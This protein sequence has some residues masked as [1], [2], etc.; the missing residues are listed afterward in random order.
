MNKKNL[1]EQT[2]EK[3][4]T[5]IAVEK[6]IKAGHKLPNE[7][8]LS[9]Q[10]GVSRTTLREAIRTLTARGVLE[11]RRG[12]G[13]FVSEK[14]GEI[15]DFGFSNLDQMR[16]RL[17]DLFELR[18][19]FEP[20]AAGLACRRATDEELAE[21]LR[22]GE[23]VEQYIRT[24]KDRTAADRE[25]HTAIVRAAHNEFMMRLLPMINQAVGEAI[26][27]GENAEA[28]AEHTLRDHALLMD[29]LRKRDEAGAEHAMA[30]HMHH[31]IDA[32]NLE[33]K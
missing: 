14:I 19:I 10:M 6:R 1:S 9:Q 4:Y 21:I 8:V 23:M 25:F 31:G 24:G 20:R 5:I 29:F 28:L 17:M 11:V 2:T 30:I 33:K 27:A 13:T 22:R 32:L 18:S 26:A 16:G 12:R 3:L 7:L 15:E